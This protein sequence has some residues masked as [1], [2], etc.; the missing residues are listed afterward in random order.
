MTCSEVGFFFFSSFLSSLTATGIAVRPV[1]RTL[2]T[3]PLPTWAS[4][5]QQTPG[6]GRS[7][8]GAAVPGRRG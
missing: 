6:R 4:A 2:L 7:D 5:A 3:A 8:H 1:A